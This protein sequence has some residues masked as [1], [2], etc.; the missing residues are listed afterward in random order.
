MPG[1]NKVEIIIKAATDKA[2]KD[3]RQFVDGSRRGFDDMAGASD[4][5]AGRM[6][7]AW[8]GAAHKVGL[9]QSAAWPNEPGINYITV[10]YGSFYK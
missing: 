4:R 3:V 8:A 1:E 6:K 2:A 10:E 7:K 5:A 9:I